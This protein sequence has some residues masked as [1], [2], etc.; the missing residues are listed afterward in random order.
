VEGF[1]S[2]EFMTDMEVT[3][4]YV[5]SIMIGNEVAD[6]VKEHLINELKKL[7]SFKS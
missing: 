6:Y 1:L 5:S 3:N 4:L 7:E 2:S